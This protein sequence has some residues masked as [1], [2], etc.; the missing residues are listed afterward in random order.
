MVCRA[1]R[2]RHHPGNHH[3]RL[4]SNLTHPPT[5]N[6]HLGM[7][8]LFPAIQ[9]KH[10][11]PWAYYSKKMPCGTWLPQRLEDLCL[12]AARCTAPGHNSRAT[13]GGHHNRYY[14]YYWQR[15]AGIMAISLS[16]VE[17]LILQSKNAVK[18]V[19]SK[20]LLSTLQPEPITAT[21][22]QEDRDF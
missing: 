6:T 2:S 10:G 16:S 22:L 11:E 20:I 5:C 12:R 4:S 13:P 15:V 19:I 21:Q 7:S 14:S 18:R 9:S 3:A 8:H 1:A 17:S